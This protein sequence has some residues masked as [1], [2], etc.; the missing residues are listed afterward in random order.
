MSV[1]NHKDHSVHCLERAAKGMCQLTVKG[2]IASKLAWP[3]VLAYSIT[4]D[5]GHLQ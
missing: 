4:I 2:C 5:S 1:Y 3:F